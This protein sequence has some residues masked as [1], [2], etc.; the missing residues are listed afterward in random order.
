M[1]ATGGASYAV[2]LH[3]LEVMEGS[4]NHVV[5][6]LDAIDNRVQ[7]IERDE[8]KTKAVIVCVEDHEDRI[9]ELEKL[10]PA[11]KAVIWLA[12]VLGVSVFA[13]IWSLITGQAA[14]LFK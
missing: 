12:A 3:K 8:V 2:V 4:I 14:I 10:A 11:M 6:K 5:T 9:R 13:L 1:P 7:S